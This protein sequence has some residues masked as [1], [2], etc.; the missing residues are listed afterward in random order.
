MLA[1]LVAERK[2]D[3]TINR[4]KL[5]EV[6]FKSDIVEKSFANLSCSCSR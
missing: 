3:E 5:V 6:V 4:R 2:N 1:I